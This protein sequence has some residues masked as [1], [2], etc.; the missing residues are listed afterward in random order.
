MIADWKC[1]QLPDK[2][3]Q[4]SFLKDDIHY[5]RL[6]I[7]LTNEV[8]K[9]MSNTQGNVPLSDT[10]RNK[11]SWVKTNRKI[12]DRNI[13]TNT[14]YTT[15]MINSW[16]YKKTIRHTC[17]HYS[18]KNKRSSLIISAGTKN[19]KKWH[20]TLKKSQKENQEQKHIM[21]KISMGCFTCLHIIKERISNLEERFEE[22]K[23][24]KHWGTMGWK[25]WRK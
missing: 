20:S 13:A 18:I 16:R 23:H 7:I 14:W 25:I 9:T 17:L 2:R 6:Q 24:L 19:Y 5:S 4:K 15:L 21:K 10:Q 1:L 8:S 22:T 3:K 12:G 11:T